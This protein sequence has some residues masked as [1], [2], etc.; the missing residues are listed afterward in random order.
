MNKMLARKRGYYGSPIETVPNSISTTQLVYNFYAEEL[1][2]A[3]WLDSKVNS[4]QGK[5]LALMQKKMNEIVEIDTQE[6]CLVHGE[7]TPSH[8]FIIDNDEIGIIDIESVKY[9]DF[10]YDWAVI[11]LM[12]GGKIPLPIN[13]NMKKLEFY[14]ICLKVG[15]VSVAVDFLTHVDSSNIFFKNIRK[16]NLQDLEMIV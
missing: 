4:L 6:Y 2:I 14:K 7:L 9:F 10:E 13:I 12:Y 1:N 8:I 11:D 3:S 5:I 16:S 15:Y